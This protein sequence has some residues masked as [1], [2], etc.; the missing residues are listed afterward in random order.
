MTLRQDLDGVTVIP[1]QTKGAHLRLDAAGFTAV[2]KRNE[3]GRA[4]N[5]VAGFRPA[6]VK[7]GT[8]S[9][10]ISGSPLYQIGF[11]LREP[12]RKGR[13]GRWI[14]RRTY[15]VDDTLPGVYPDAEEIVELMERWRQHHS[16]A[17]PE[18]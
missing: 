2:T 3:K 4:W 6:N 1:S 14:V 15:G 13:V 9:G 5:E 7:M 16:T 17:G 11:F 18:D 10:E 8:P 12:P